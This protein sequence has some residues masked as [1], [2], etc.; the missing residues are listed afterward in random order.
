MTMCT[1]TDLPLPRYT[2]VFMYSV[3]FVHVDVQ[4]ACV[5]KKVGALHSAMGIVVRYDRSIIQLNYTTLCS[6]FVTL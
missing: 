2:V 5:N 6:Y 1:D 3:Q 4:Y